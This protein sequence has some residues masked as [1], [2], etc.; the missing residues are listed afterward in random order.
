MTGS[1]QRRR[2]RPKI[3]PV[4]QRRRMQSSV[5]RLP[6]SITTL[7]DCRLKVTVYPAE[8]LVD[9]F[10]VFD[11]V[12]AC[13]ADMDHFFG[14]RSPMPSRFGLEFD[15]RSLRLD[16]DTWSGSKVNRRIGE[17]VGQAVP[18]VHFAHRDLT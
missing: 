16:K 18:S 8:A 3:E 15:W 13:V 5:E 10:D 14:E 11:A 17:F 2:T 7:S 12:G 4:S 1:N 6:R 9:A